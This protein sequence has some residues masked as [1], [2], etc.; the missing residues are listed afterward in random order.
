M[1]NK[2]ISRYNK[3]DDSFKRTDPWKEAEWPA[4]EGLSIFVTAASVLGF[5]LVIALIICGGVLWDFI[6]ELPL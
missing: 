1:N 6:T 4:D 3:G 2:Y 5:L